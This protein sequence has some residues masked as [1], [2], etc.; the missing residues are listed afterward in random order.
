MKRWFKPVNLILMLFFTAPVYSAPLALE[1][2][3]ADASGN[4]N[5]TATGYIEFRDESYFTIDH[6][7]DAYWNAYYIGGPSDP[8][9]H[10]DTGISLASITVESDQLNALCRS[11][12]GRKTADTHL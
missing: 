6:G 9:F 10:K 8:Y 12:S 3:Y 5:T 4:T 1:L 2:K 11:Y 7:R